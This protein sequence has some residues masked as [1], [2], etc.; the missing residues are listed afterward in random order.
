MLSKGKNA[1]MKSKLAQMITCLIIGPRL[2]KSCQD[3]QFY[4]EYLKLNKLIAILFKP[5]ESWRI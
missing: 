1:D 3:T 5:G 2:S 4:W